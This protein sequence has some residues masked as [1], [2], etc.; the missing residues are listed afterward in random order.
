MCVVTAP[1]DAS[2]QARRNEGKVQARL[3]QL[4]ALRNLVQIRREKVEAGQEDIDIRPHGL[5]HRHFRSAL[6]LEIHLLLKS[7]EYLKASH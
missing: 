4:R 7:I 2:V 6:A 5:L 3:E 1:P